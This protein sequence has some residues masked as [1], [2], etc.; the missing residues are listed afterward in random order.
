MQMITV[1]FDYTEQTHPKTVPICICDTD[2]KG[3]P[4]HTA[5][6]ESGVIPVAE[7]L[8]RIADR[9][10]GDKFRTSEIA[11]YAVHS[12]SRIY[13][14]NIGERPSVKVL[15]RAKHHAVDLR[16][17]GRRARCNFDVE[18]YTE[19]LNGLQDQYDL[20][21]HLENSDTLD[22]LVEQVDRL[23]LEKVKTALPFML[24]NAERKELTAALGEKGNTIT[25][26]FYRGMR[27][28]AET[29]GI[30]WT[31]NHQ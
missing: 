5:W 21:A 1:P 3:N 17:G 18:L 30:S 20:A 6:I 24:K 19:T 12:L 13:G 9:L 15:N 22:K 29:A 14:Q 23:G 7:V 31:R 4:V 2:A 27:F 16:A 10:L 25:T 28:A 8:V 26:R 11:E